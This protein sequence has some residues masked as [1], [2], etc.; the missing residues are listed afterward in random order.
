MIAVILVGDVL[1]RASS[2]ATPPGWAERG[3]LTAILFT[4]LWSLAAAGAGAIGAWQAAERGAPD[5]AAVRLAGAL[6]PVAIDR[7]RQPWALGGDDASP[8]RRS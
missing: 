2:S 7:A 3:T 1:R 8:S 6:G 5:H 4:A